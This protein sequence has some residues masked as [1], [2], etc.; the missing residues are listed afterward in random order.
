M[1]LNKKTKYMNI[2]FKNVSQY[3]R[4]QKKTNEKRIGQDQP[5]PSGNWL[6]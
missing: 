2:L 4:E 1:I 5:Y 6:A 3:V